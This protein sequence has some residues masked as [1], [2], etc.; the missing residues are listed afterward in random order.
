MHPMQPPGVPLGRETDVCRSADDGEA[1]AAARAI[2]G[3]IRPM[4]ARPWPFCLENRKPDPLSTPPQQHQQH[5]GGFAIVHHRKRHHPD[6][7][8][9]DDDD[10]DDYD[11]SGCSGAEAGQGSPRG[12]GSGP[13]AGR[14]GDNRAGDPVAARKMKM[15]KIA[16]KMVNLPRHRPAQ[17][18]ASFAAAAGAAEQVPGARHDG[19]FILKETAVRYRCLIPAG[20]G[21]RLDPT[22]PGQRLE[23]PVR[24]IA[25]GEVAEIMG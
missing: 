1:A 18:H 21:V 15:T 23:P 3:L 16:R 24:T 2:V 8:S 10:D 11:D 6:D 7:S 12:G 20:V 22:E 14:T 5:R 19:R 17:P 13:D 9:V 25:H 4:P